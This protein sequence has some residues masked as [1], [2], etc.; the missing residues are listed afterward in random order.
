[1][2]VLLLY[3]PLSRNVCFSVQ[4][5]ITA[6]AS[7]LQLAY[8]EHCPKQWTGEI[9]PRYFYNVSNTVMY[10]SA[11]YFIGYNEE[12]FSRISNDNLC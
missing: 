4:I 7:D 1:M 5:Q 8:S 3:V 11:A 12:L 6:E 9:L 10:I 2:A